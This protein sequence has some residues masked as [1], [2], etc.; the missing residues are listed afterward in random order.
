MKENVKYHIYDLFKK[1]LL[2]FVLNDFTYNDKEY[3]EFV[4]IN[5]DMDNKNKKHCIISK[6]KMKHV[7]DLYSIIYN[8]AHYSFSIFNK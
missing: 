8:N 3:N 4:S 1:N 7:K 2:K 5:K 6:E